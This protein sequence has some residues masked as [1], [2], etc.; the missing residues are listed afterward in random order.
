MLRGVA[1]RCANVCENGTFASSLCGYG[2]NFFLFFFSA[3]V[4]LFYIYYSS[5]PGYTFISPKYVA[6]R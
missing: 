6:G 3:C 5:H 2:K 1:V 4:S